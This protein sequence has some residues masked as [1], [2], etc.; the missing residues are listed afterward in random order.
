MRDMSQW[1]HYKSYTS[2]HTTRVT[3]RSF[4]QNFLLT[5]IIKAATPPPSVL[6]NFI[7]SHNI[8]P[9]WDDIPLPTGQYHDRR[10]YLDVVLCQTATLSISSEPDH[11]A[12]QD[13]KQISGRSLNSCKTAFSQPSGA[14][15]Y[16]PTFSQ[17]SG[18]ASYPPPSRVGSQ[19]GPQTPHTAPTALKRQF[20]P[21]ALFNI[22]GRE[23][24]P[25]PSPASRVY[26]QPSGS[27]SEPPAKRKR[28]RP[29]KAEQQAKRDRESAAHGTAP[30]AQ[31][32]LETPALV[33]PISAGPFE[34]TK[35]AVTPISRISITSVL[36]PNQP[37]SASQSASSGS[38]GKRRRGRSG[39]KREAEAGPGSGASGKLPMRQPEYGSPY[40]AP[41]I[42]DLE[43]ETIPRSVM[44][45]SYEE[46]QPSSPHRSSPSE[47]ER[48]A[49]RP[50]PPR[51]GG[52]FGVE[53]RPRPPPP[54]RE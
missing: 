46:I 6:Y 38:S 43:D 24:R 35:P 8:D 42:M 12:A 20:Q 27:A 41:A 11:T 23:I 5:E 16:P 52:P 48:R 36:T 39:S 13:T 1:H 33:T 17:L 49:S 53:A 3:N 9:R 4:D 29:T 45:R 31:M 40:R 26:G 22:G 19:S 15:S 18:A 37:K 25:K 50:P 21:E 10:G 51:L 28:G 30:P 44:R 2:S 54:P 47:G 14:A 34:E 32:R 7:K